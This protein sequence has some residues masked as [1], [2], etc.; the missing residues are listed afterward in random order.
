[1]ERRFRVTVD[2]R[3]YDVTVED[4]SATPSS[5][6]PQPGDMRMPAPESS[7][8]QP[9]PAP[10]AVPGGSD[11]AALASPL[12]GVVL[13]VDVKEGDEVRSG[14]QV[15][16]VEAMKMKTAVMAHR[17]GRVTAVHVRPGDALES[18]QSL[19]SIE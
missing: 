6:L 19:M 2:G 3:E 14:Q 9:A 11:P 7:T 13:E 8:A 17:S 16:A 15:A 18:G 4:L 10:A 1:M 5:I 12:A